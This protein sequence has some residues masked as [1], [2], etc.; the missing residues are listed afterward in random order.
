MYGYSAQEK[1]RNLHNDM[2]RKYRAGEISTRDWEDF[3]MNFF[4]TSDKIV[5]GILEQKALMKASKKW[6]VDLNSL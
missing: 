1:L 5:E 6:D 2:G 4:G 3:R